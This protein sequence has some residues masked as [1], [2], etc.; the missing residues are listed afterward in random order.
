MVGNYCEPIGGY[1]LSASPNH[2]YHPKIACPP[3]FCVN[4]IS[5]KAVMVLHI[6]ED[7][8]VP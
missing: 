2:G 4:K 1:V 7:L 5:T 8:Y 6:L 3:I